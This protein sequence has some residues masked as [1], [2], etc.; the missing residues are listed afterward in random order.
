M[1]LSRAVY[2]RDLK[3]ATMRALDAGNTTGEIARKYQLSPKLLERWRGEW[4]AKGESAFPGIGR[5][6]ADSTALD[7]GRRI[8]E[9][10]RKIGQLTM[11]NDFL[12]KALQH[13]RDHH[14]PAIASGA[15][16]CL[17]KSSKPRR[18]AKP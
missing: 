18:K 9:L 12:K 5:R 2:S 16:A 10:E 8:A 6:G 3:I 4:R 1:D 11:E 7:E 15:D 13:F 14:P 17:E